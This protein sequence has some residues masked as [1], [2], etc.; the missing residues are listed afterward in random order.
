MARLRV[1]RLAGGAS[2]T[3]N[4]TPY[5]LASV[6]VYSRPTSQAV[7]AMSMWAQ[8]VSSTNSSRKEAAVIVPA[9][10]LAARLERSATVP[11]ISS[12]NSGWRG[13]RQ[14]SSPLRSPARETSPASPSSLEIT[15]A[16]VEPRA[17]TTAP[18]R[19]AMSTTRSAPCSTA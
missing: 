4:R 9:F 10:R 11:F 13:R 16:K 8:G 14:V 1:S 6:P 17:I 5:P 3:S 12:L 2:S 15:A 7:P 18:V 19:V